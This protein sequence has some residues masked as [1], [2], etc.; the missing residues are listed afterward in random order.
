MA[1]GRGPA[2]KK[3]G[4]GKQTAAVIGQRQS[5][6]PPGTVM[7]GGKCY[8]SNTGNLHMRKSTPGRKRTSAV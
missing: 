1:Q 2:K 8:N 7:R 6:C 5:G 3:G 4:K